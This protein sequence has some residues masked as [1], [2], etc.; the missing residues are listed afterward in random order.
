MKFE[1]FVAILSLIMTGFGFYI[2]AL[3]CSAREPAE[4]VYALGA[5]AIWSI[6]RAM[7]DGLVQAVQ[8]SRM[9]KKN[10]PWDI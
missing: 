1:T 9:D 6:L 10:C 4:T 5:F 8:I 7:G 2:I 3:V